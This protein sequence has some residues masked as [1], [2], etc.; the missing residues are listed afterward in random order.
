MMS[1]DATALR[2]DDYASIAI[3][4]HGTAKE[5]AMTR[6]RKL[7]LLAMASLATSL[8]VGAR[9]APLLEQEHARGM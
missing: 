3:P 8:L 2:R 7:V 9:A 5:N 6:V 4:V 1:A